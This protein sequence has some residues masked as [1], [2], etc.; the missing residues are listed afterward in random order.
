MA[1]PVAPA[2][3]QTRRAERGGI[4]LCGKLTAGIDALRTGNA[5]DRQTPGRVSAKFG[6]GRLQHG[7]H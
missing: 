7:S 6:D 1:N 5:I 4:E 3:E 2:I